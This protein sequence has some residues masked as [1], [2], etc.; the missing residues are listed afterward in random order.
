MDYCS[1]YSQEVVMYKVTEFAYVSF[2]F[3]GMPCSR[4]PLLLFCT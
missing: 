4:I 2:C 3:R 1:D